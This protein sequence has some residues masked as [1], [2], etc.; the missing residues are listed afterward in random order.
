MR[1]GSSAAL[2]CCRVGTIIMAPTSNPKRSP[3]RAGLR[4]IA[5]MAKRSGGFPP[6]FYS[7]DYFATRLID[8]LGERPAKG[9]ERPFFAYLAFTAPHWPLQAPAEDIARYK[10]RYD[11]GFDI[12]RERR[13]ARQR[14][15][16]ILG[17]DVAAHTRATA[18]AAGIR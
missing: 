8:F 12:L 14:E 3:V 10:G 9:K 1:A 11:A 7:S 16:G 13:L 17:A 18:T 6:T 2:R 4:L 15:L 5:R